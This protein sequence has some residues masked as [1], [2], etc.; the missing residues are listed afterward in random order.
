MLFRSVL[1][2][3]FAAQ[4]INAKSLA[5]KDRAPP[6][7]EFQ[8]SRLPVT[9]WSHLI[10]P[11]ILTLAQAVHPRLACPPSHPSG[12]KAEWY[13]K[14]SSEL[15][16][17]HAMAWLAMH[18]CLRVALESDDADENAEPLSAEDF[19]KAEKSVLKAI[20][21]SKKDSCDCTPEAIEILCVW[22]S[23][24]YASKNPLNPIYDEEKAKYWEEKFKDSQ[25]NAEK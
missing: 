16:S 5:W 24:V 12:K 21:E 25:K 7:P 1:K 3:P 15:G 14:K 19:L 17:V 2:A 8:P 11:G 6:N 22:L 4:K 20:E 23:K 18:D 10:L 9:S 13:F